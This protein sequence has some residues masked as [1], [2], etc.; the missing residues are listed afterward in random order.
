M[1]IRQEKEIKE[2]QIGKDE[3][4]LSLF[5]F[6]IILY[7]KNPKDSTK[8]PL[9]LINKFSQVAGYKI[10]VQKTAVF[11]FIYLFIFG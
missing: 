5:A 10:N 9:Y 6:N 4:K 2:I 3:V 7:M 8:I 11:Y 1:S